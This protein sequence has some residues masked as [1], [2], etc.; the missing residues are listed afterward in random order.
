MKRMG[1]ERE[2][3]KIKEIK[4]LDLGVYL[5]L[6]RRRKYTLFSYQKKKVYAGWCL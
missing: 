6:W 1:E 4:F 2:N 5:S 3:N